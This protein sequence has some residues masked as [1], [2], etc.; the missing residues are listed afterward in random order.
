MQ[1]GSSKAISLPARW[2]DWYKRLYGAEPSE[3]AIEVD[4]VLIIRPILPNK[5]TIEGESKRGGA[6][7]G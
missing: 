4:E 6:Q 7:H 1:I 2:L 3:V 5:L